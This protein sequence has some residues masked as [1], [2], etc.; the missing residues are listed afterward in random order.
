[1]D[2][3]ESMAHHLEGLLP[4]TAMRTKAA[5]MIRHLRAELQAEREHADRLAAAARM[6]EFAS[7]PFQ[8]DDM[9][10]T[11]TERRKK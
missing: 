6:V 3:Y 9:L 1:M 10:R 4:K 2:K 7:S 8:L 11:H 5:K